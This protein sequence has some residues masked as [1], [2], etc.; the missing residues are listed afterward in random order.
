MIASRAATECCGAIAGS[1]AAG[2]VAFAWIQGSCFALLLVDALPGTP[3]LPE[4]PDVVVVV[5]LLVGADVATVE[6][7]VGVDAAATAGPNVV[8]PVATA[9]TAGTTNAGIASAGNCWCYPLRCRFAFEAA[10]YFAACEGTIRRRCPVL[11]AEG[12]AGFGAS[13]CFG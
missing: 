13:Y 1:A 3:A 7:A 9:E 2:V 5:A 6:A 11:V 10:E 8:G 4:T 12:F